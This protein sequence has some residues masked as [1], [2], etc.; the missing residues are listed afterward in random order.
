LKRV[1]GKHGSNEPFGRTRTKANSR[2]GQRAGM[3]S[4]SWLRFVLITVLSIATG[5]RARQLEVRKKPSASLTPSSGGY[6]RDFL[7][8]VARLGNSVRF[9]H[10]ARFVEMSDDG[11]PRHTEKRR[12]PG[13]I[14]RLAPT[15]SQNSKPMRFLSRNRTST[16]CISN[17]AP[18]AS[19]CRSRISGSDVPDTC[20]QS[21]SAVPVGRH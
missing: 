12:V 4:R 15:Q 11:Q 2:R 7:Q 3:L 20:P 5:R 6:T 1:Y 9:S 21:P 17:S 13:S 19:G 14:C 10:I 18:Q 16:A 8:S